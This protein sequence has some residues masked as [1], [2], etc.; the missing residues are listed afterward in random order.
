MA[1]YGTAEGPAAHLSWYYKDVSAVTQGPFP[2]ASMRSW[3]EAGFFN[4]KTVVAKH[5]DHQVLWFPVD[6]L[7][8][9]PGSQAFHPKCLPEF[10][11]PK[12]S[13]E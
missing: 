11:T 1:E 4:E 7:W 8:K 10:P 12:P 2:A 3:Y 6:D 5:G 9:R 13:N